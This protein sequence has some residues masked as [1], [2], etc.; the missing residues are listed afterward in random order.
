[1]KPLY[2]GIGSR[3]TP[4]EVM[5]KMTTMAGILAKHGFTLRSGAA[6]GADT[7]FEQGAGT[8]KEIWLPWSGFNRYSGSHLLP[9]PAHFQLAST[10]HPVWNAL[11][12]P[13][14]ALHARNTGQ[15][16]GMDLKTPVKFVVC[17]TPDGAESLDQVTRKTGGT[18]TAI[19]LARI[20]NI[21]VINL[22]NDNYLDKLKDVVRYL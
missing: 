14:K 7:A 22:Y 3:V 16:L 20:W 9:T 12:N 13:I 8:E 4:L 21:P 1:M 19:K 15:I 11:E 5:N 10:L 2:A 17:W 18:G 6:N